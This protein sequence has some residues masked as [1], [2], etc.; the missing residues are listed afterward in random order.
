MDRFGEEEFTEALDNNL[1]VE[2]LGFGEALV[3]LR[4]EK[5]LARKAWKKG[6]W[7]VLEEDTAVHESEV[8]NFW[9]K[10]AIKENGLLIK[11]QTVIEK[12]P[13]N[14]IKEWTPTVEDI[15]SLDWF[16]VDEF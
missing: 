3:Y 14:K 4:Y 12:S 8:N 2:N 10:D 13:D 5:R 15:L 11:P 9:L 1:K 16:Q 7:I 6:T